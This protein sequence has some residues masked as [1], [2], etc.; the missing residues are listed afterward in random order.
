MRDKTLKKRNINFC[1]INKNQ[2]IKR[3]FKK[4]EKI[5]ILSPL[6]RFYDNDMLNIKQFKEQLKYVE[7]IFVDNSPN[8]EILNGFP[9]SSYTKNFLKLNTDNK[10][11]LYLKSFNNQE[12]GTDIGFSE[13]DAKKLKKWANMSNNEKV[14]VFDWDGC[15]STIEGIIIPSTQKMEEEYKHSGI[16]DKDI[17]IYYA[18]GPK[19]F[20]MLNKLFQYL[21]KKH[22]RVFILKN[23][24]S[25]SCKSSDFINI[26]PKSRDNFYKVSRQIIPQINKEDILCG[27]DDNCIKP[28]TFLKNDYLRNVY[29][30]NQV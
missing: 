30:K 27:Y 28:V 29:F 2:T 20:Q 12:I 6:I 3:N 7:S 4:K 5:K 16:T 1:K 24:P 8:K 10:F 26:G 14:V 13:K 9:A 19:R 22:V 17:A 18:G 23:N 25:A 21:N 15:I 11:A